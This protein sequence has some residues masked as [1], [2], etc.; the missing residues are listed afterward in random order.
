MTPKTAR[1]FGRTTLALLAIALL[2]PASSGQVYPWEMGVAWDPS[3]SRGGIAG[4][5]AAMV[6]KPPTLLRMYLVLQGK[7]KSAGQALASLQQRRAAAI[8]ELEKLGADPKT[9]DPAAPSISSEDLQQRRQLEQMIRSRMRSGAKARKV[10]LPE[11]VTVTSMLTAQWPLPA[12]AAE[13]LFVMVQKIESQV[14]AARLATGKEADQ[15]SEEEKELA[16][17]M[18]S[19]FDQM[20]SFGQEQADPNTP[21]FLYFA[22]IAPDERARAL[23][24][25]FEKAKADGQRTARAVGVLLGVLADVTTTSTGGSE[26][27]YGYDGRFGSNM[28]RAMRQLLSEQQYQMR[29]ENQENEASSPSPEGIVFQFTAMARFTQAKAAGAAAGAPL[30][31]ALRET[32]SGT[33]NAVVQKFPTA[34]RMT[35]SIPGKGKNLDEALADLHQRRQAAFAQFEKL[36]AKKESLKASVPSVSPIEAQQRRQIQYG[37]RSMRSRG[38]GA[39]AVKPPETVTLLAGLTAEWPVEAKNA[40]ALFIA[41]QRLRESI[42]AARLAGSLQAA[43]PSPEDEDMQEKLEEGIQSMDID[44]IGM[45]GG[46]SANGTGGVAPSFVFVAAI[47]DEERQQALAQAAEKAKADAARVAESVGARLGPLASVSGGSASLRLGGSLSP[48]LMPVPLYPGRGIAV[49]DA[50]GAGKENEGMASEPGPVKFTF[51]AQASFALQSVTEPS[52]KGR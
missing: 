19:D 17:E 36:G 18:G 11:I 33:G 39:K 20:M 44:V 7:G 31:P 42:E 8:A 34:M 2:S 37:P 21:Y 25:A 24:E 1:I 51:T 12:K 38:S 22:E 10:K 52:T 30:G 16:E 13:D 45:T 9:I 46:I 40:E 41:V 49:F 27:P 4:S 6:M 14:K 23:A 29:R 26:S 15:Q 32:V 43:K 3:N 5:G 28:P 35:M 47:T 50:S 48:R